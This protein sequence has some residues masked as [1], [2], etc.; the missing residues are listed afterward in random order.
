MQSHPDTQILR[1]KDR[2]RSHTVCFPDGH[3]LTDSECENLVWQIS[4]LGDCDSDNILAEIMASSRN[5]QPHNHA[6][7]FVSK[8]YKR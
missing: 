8:K 4:G 6:V 5:N 3:I 7:I 1:I 2:C